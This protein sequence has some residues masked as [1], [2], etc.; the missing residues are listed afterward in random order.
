MFQNIEKKGKH[1]NYE[2]NT[3]LIQKP[4]KII[5]KEKKM[6]TKLSYHISGEKMD[7]S[8]SSISPTT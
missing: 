8:I 3:T 7:Y 2:V 5:Q 6:M 4:S 1:I